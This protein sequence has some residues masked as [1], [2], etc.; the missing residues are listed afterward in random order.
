MTFRLPCLDQSIDTGLVACDVPLP[1]NT[2]DDCV[3]TLSSCWEHDDASF[4][5]SKIQLLE[6]DARAVATKLLHTETW[7]TLPDLVQKMR[8]V[9]CLSVTA[10]GHRFSGLPLLYICMT[11]GFKCPVC[12]YGNNAEIDITAAP[13]DH[14]CANVWEAMCVLCNVV[15]KR[16]RLEKLELER[17]TAM[18][19]ARQ[20]ISVVYLSLPWM[21]RFVLYKDPNPGMASAPFAQIPIKMCI[22]RTTVLQSRN[23]Q[24]P[25]T[26]NLTAGMCRIFR[27][28]TLVSDRVFW[29]STRPVVSVCACAKCAKVY[30]EGC[31]L[32]CAWC[33]M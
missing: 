15:R 21:L 26:I 31:R 19:M 32:D 30:C 5:T 8:A 23:G 20:T 18:M 24:L 1:P 14:L 2:E 28:I 10:C 16:D 27:M 17:F 4:L 22:D 9:G 3:L 11:T 25:D 7:K 29:K 6:E 33:P 13:P 12:R